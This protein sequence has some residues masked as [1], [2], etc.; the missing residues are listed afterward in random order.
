MT[1]T[2]ADVERAVS[3][4]PGGAGAPETAGSGTATSARGHAAGSRLA[5]PTT[6]FRAWGGQP[7]SPPPT[8]LARAALFSRA[9][10]ALVSLVGRR[11]LQVVPFRHVAELAGA[12]GGC[13]DRASQDTQPKRHRHLSVRESANGRRR[14]AALRAP[15]GDGDEQPGPQQVGLLLYCGLLATRA[16]GHATWSRERETH[17]LERTQ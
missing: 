11:R 14:F 10:A 7:V 9:A 13:Q 12:S 8:R 17:R 15:L 3:G 5:F 16:I 2:R 4:R 6:R 1:A